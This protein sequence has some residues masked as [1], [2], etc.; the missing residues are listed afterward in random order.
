[1]HSRSRVPPLVSEV[2]VNV[3]T[4]DGKRYILDCSPCYHIMIVLEMTKN[5]SLGLNE[6]YSEGTFDPIDSILPL[7]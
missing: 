7:C 2:F 4:L 6:Y 1:M 5:P 3:R